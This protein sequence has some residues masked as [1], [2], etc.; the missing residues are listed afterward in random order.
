MDLKITFNN[1]EYTPIYNNDTGYYELKLTAPEKGGVYPAE[2]S[3][4]D[5]LGNT[6]TDE[7][8][9]QIKTRQVEKFETNDLYMW[10]F[11]W[12]DF[13][14]KD[15]VQL[16]SP[17]II[18]DEETNGNSTVMVLKE[19][20]ACSDDIVAIKRNGNVVFWGIIENIQNA[21]GEAKY[22]YTLKYI[23]NMFNQKIE[24]KYEEYIKTLGVEDFIVRAIQDNFMYNTDLF[25]NKS[26]LRIIVKTHTIKQ[27]TVSNVEDGI[28]NLHTWMTNCTQ[29][30]N[31]T[32]EFSIVDG[33]L[34]LTIENKEQS[35]LLVDTNAMNIADYEEVFE[36]NITAKVVVLT[37]T[38][39]YTLFLK[40][41]RTTTTNQNDPDRA[42][43]KVE[44]I[45]T[46]DYA[47]APQSALDVI[48]ANT[49]NH[50]I[51]FK[52]NKFIPIGTPIAIKTKKS[53]IYDTYISS[54][55]ITDKNF[56]EYECGNIRIN[57]IEKLLKERGK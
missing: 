38:N 45:Y 50:N 49:Y 56:Y 43:G 19:T 37:A 24:L 7:K 1:T 44:T 2:I 32:Y 22:I 33:K 51:T 29:L 41:D 5:L 16:S 39:T 48:R 42:Y 11:S 15:I 55:K 6:Y 52:L 30:Y 35:K 57:F 13:S 47:D 20:T 8:D 25:V 10:I 9:I 28:Y 53:L 46:E 12:R 23:T 31:I 40:N 17:E 36:T 26:Y 3:F 18:E 4:T 54:I 27:T 21:S 34:V 14:V